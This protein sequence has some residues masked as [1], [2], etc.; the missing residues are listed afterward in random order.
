[1]RDEVQHLSKL[2]GKKVTRCSECDTD[3]DD[4][5]DDDNVHTVLVVVTYMYVQ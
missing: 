3:D 1:M 5:D 4:D 2:F